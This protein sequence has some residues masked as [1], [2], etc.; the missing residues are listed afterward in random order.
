MVL[1]STPP[2]KS[3]YWRNKKKLQKFKVQINNLVEWG[4]IKLNKLP[5]G[6]PILFMDKKDKKLHMCIDYR[7]LN[8]ITIKNNYPLLLIDDL[9]HCLKRAS[10]FN[11]IDLKSGYY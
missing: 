5:Y 8:K 1:G 9:F 4:Y 10:Y 2:F 11:Q 3:L 7:A 6:S